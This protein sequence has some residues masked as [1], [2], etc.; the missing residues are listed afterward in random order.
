MRS[1]SVAGTEAMGDNM[2]G[3]GPGAR[4]FMLATVLGSPNVPPGPL[5][6][7]LNLLRPDQGFLRSCCPVA[8]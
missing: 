8:Q 7:H 3:T 5:G 4:T 2:Q 6:P 1:H